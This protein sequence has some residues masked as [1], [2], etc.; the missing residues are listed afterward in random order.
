MIIIEAEQVDKLPK[1]IL[2]CIEEY[3]KNPSP[4]LFLILSGSGVSGSSAFYKQVE[5]VGIVLE[6]AEEKGTS[7]EKSH[8]DIATKR[9]LAA[10]K[11]IDAKACQY[12]VTHLGGEPSLLFQEVDKLV[13]YV[14]ERPH[15]T[16]EDVKSIC[17]NI[18]NDTIWQL[19]EALFKRETATALRIIRT[20]LHAG[21]SFLALLRQIRHQFQTEYQVCSILSCGGS[22]GDVTQKFP[23]MKGYVLDRHL[24]MARGYGITRFKKAML[25]LDA[26]ELQAKNDGWDDDLLADLLITKLVT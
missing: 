14:G 4:S 20:M 12:L 26:M 6:L 3:C 16:L 10:G 18:D 23:Y 25:A 13:T 9:V 2:K 17:V 1:P 24:Q 11:Q 22:G 21:T 7:K 5:K 19:G 8:I 15:I